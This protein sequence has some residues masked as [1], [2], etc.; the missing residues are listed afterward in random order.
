MVEES[1]HAEVVATEVR[2]HVLI[3]TLGRPAKKNAFNVAMLRGLAAAYTRLEADDD[4]RCGLLVAEGGDFTAGLD[5]AEVGPLVARGADLFGGGEGASVDPLDL[6][7]ARR[8][9]PVV[10]GARG[11]CFT[12]GVELMLAADVRL[13]AQDTVFAQMEVQRGI[14][15]F[16]GATL[17]FAAQ[18]GWGNAMRWMLTGARFDAAEALRIGLVQEVVPPDALDARAFAIARDIA[19]QAPLAVQATRESARIAR[20]EGVDAAREALMPAA[21]ALFATDDAREGVASFVA[22]REARFTGR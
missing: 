18:C 10:V 11:Y 14:M 17:R 19:R 2:D 20:D 12:I 9:K 8:R 3:I 6:G 22:R 13:A 5:L 4:A 21:R 16:G 15:P 1:A 7:G